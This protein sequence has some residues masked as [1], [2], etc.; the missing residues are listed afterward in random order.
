[1]IGDERDETI[2]R[3]AFLAG[4]GAAGMAGAVGLSLPLLPSLGHTSPNDFPK[5]LVVFFSANGTIAPNWRPES[6]DGTITDLSRILEPLRPHLDDLAVIEGLDLDVGRH[7]WQPG[8]FHGHERGLG[9]ILTG[10]NLRLGDFVEGSG[11]ADGESVDQFI[12]DR[13]KG[14][15]DIHSLQVGINTPRHGNGDYNRDTMVYADAGKPRFHQDDGEKLFDTIFGDGATRPEVYKRIRKRRRSV[16]DFL[17]SDLERLRGRVSSE[18]R[19]RLERH[20][21]KYRKL[22]SKLEQPPP[23]CQ[24]SAPPE[25]IDRWRN[26]N[27]MDEIS[28]FQIQQTVQALACDRTRVATIQ[29]GKGLGAL[30]LRCIGLDDRWHS[31]SHE[32]DGNQSAQEKLTKMNRYIAERFS[33]LLDEMKSIPEGDGTLLDNSVVLWVNELGKGNTHDYDDVP[34]VMA[35]N[36]QGF[37]ETGGRHLEFDGRPHN[38]LLITLCHAFGHTDVDEF[39]IPDLCSGPIRELMA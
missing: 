9:G 37:F 4:A 31:L 28:Q 3:R 21:T 14:A 6:S 34:I 39:G 13:M 32:G 38:D 17:K 5:R 1:M 7:K 24:G 36:L 16:L 30:S 12:A 20:A 33:L 27:N 35:G 18:D 29:F 23:E 22:E 25:S 10:Q 8:G 26:E 11:Y 15:T 19:E 2:G